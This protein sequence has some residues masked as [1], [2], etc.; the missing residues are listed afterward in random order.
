MNKTHTFNWHEK[1]DREQVRSILARDEIVLA[2]TDTVYGLL[3]NVTAA[4]ET[5]LRSIKSERGKKPFLVLVAGMHKLAHFAQPTARLKT[6]L[7]QVWPGPVTVIIGTY[8]LRCPDHERLRELLEHFDG[9]YSTSAN[10]SGEPA[11][12]TRGE[13]NPELLAAVDA[14]IDDEQLDKSPPSTI[15]DCRNPDA[16][17]VI[18]EGAYPVKTLEEIYGTAFRRN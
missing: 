18:R 10:R 2:S 13:I 15:L 3:C 9:L 5:K 1:R 6:F 16:I 17:A 14:F 7:E 11:A 8:A 4:A 12:Q